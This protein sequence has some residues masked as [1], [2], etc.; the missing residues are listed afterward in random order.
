MRL[1][2]VDLSI[3]GGLDRRPTMGSTNNDDTASTLISVDRA[4]LVRVQNENETLH[5]LVIELQASNVQLQSQ[6]IGIRVSINTNNI[7]MNKNLSNTNAHEK[8]DH[9]SEASLPPTK[10]TESTDNITK[11]VPK[12]YKSP[13]IT[14]FGV[15]DI[16]NLVSILTCEEA[17]G[18]EQQ[19]RTFANG[20]IKIST[21]DKQQFRRTLKV[22]ENNK[23]EFHRYRL[24][25][26]KKFRVV[27]R[28]LHPET[29]IC[30]I[31]TQ[32]SR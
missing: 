19:L 28:G 15:N 25:A 5:K 23:I 31:K 6:L 20:D 16:Q 12:T 7:I 17:P 3:R 29:D 22:L 13:P 11:S 2:E 30:E 4:L 9:N 21:K 10:R 14:A 24:K 8:T 27:V 32:R 18:H 1:F 26:E